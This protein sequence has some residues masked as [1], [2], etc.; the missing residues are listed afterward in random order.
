MTTLPYTVPIS[1]TGESQGPLSR[2]FPVSLGCLETSQTTHVLIPVPALLVSRGPWVIF[3]SGW[4]PISFRCSGE[5][6]ISWGQGRG[7]C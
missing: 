3:K 1:T 7:R 4:R 2:E 6:C 5:G